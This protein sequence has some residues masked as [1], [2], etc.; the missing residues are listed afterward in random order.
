[1]DQVTP[2]ESLLVNPNPPVNRSRSILARFSNPLMKRSA[3]IFDFDIEP[4]HPHKTYRP[5][6]IVKGQI[7]LSAFK[8]FDITHL[9][10]SLHGYAR[11]FKHQ[12]TPSEAKTAPEA[13]IN[14]KGSHG[15]EYLGNG[16]ASLFQDEQLLC[17]SGFLKKQVYKF[18]FELQF[19][20]YSLPSTIE[21]RLGLWRFQ[22]KRADAYPVR[23]RCCQL[24]DISHCDSTHGD[25]P[26]DA[27]GLQGQVRR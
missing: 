26:Y 22:G 21:V 12:C 6:D 24:H 5:G 25:Q 15:F 16:L 18:G 4:E 13:L 19:P 2:L 9:A 8:G 20:H 17:G 1:M 23:T 10:I 14:G 11:V 27:Q 7:V 3:K